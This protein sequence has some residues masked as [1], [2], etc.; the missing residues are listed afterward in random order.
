MAWLPV[1]GADQVPVGEFIQVDTGS[2]F[3]L[4]CN[5]NG[6]LF[7]IEDRCTHDGSSMLGGC[8]EGDEII[9]PW[10]GAK[11]CVR[12][13]AV[14]APPAYEDVASYPVRINGRNIEVDVPA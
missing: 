12:N 14:K 11:F 8:L 6:E 10:H 2:M 9:C 1:A 5:V 13:G 4:V 3:L 7:A